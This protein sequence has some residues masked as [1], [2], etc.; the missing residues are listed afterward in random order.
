MG[1]YQ[2]VLDAKGRMI[3][4]AR[5]REE[6]GERFVITRGLDNCLFVYPL[7][8]WSQLEQKLKALPFTRSDARAFMRFFFSGAAECELD[9]QGRV[10]VPNNL[11][12]HAKLQKDVVVIGVSSRVEVWSQEVWN[13]YSD[14][15]GMSFESIAEKMI[16]IE[17]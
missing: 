3:M 2:H 13:Q 17:L 4:P 12:D 7:S 5:F 10:L 6:L 14:E 8:E 9:K 1:E 11:R 16:D 15:T